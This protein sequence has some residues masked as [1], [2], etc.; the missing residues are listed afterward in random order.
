[1]ST[2]EA[3]ATNPPAGSLAAFLAQAGW[4]DASRTPI[5][6]DASGRRY[7]RLAGP[8]GSRILMVSPP[9]SGSVGS[10]AAIAGLLRTM[11]LSAPE[12]FSADAER[13]LALI[14]DFGD[15]SFAG[16][17]DRGA[18]PEPLLCLAVDA[19]A[20]L[21]RR[22]DARD[23]GRLALP[24]YDEDRLV[25][26]VML[27]ADVWLP[28]AFGRPAYPHERS[29]LE[30]AWRAVVRDAADL[31]WSFLH[32]DYFAG[33]LML[34]QGRDGIAACGLLDFQDA[35]FGPV[36]YDLV[37]LLEDARRDFPAPLA[38]RMVGRYLAAFPGLDPS[39]FRRGM[40]VLGAVRHTRIAAIFARLS[41]RDG[42]NGYLVHLPRVWRQLEEKLAQP[43]MTPV[44]T[45]FDAHLPP[46]L[47]AAPLAPKPI[48]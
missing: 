34:L 31:P 10:F 4:A 2:T 37:S 38:D 40:A 13:G 45:W 6:G 39:A 14:E 12:I 25:D 28:L 42:R 18:D 5:A 44:R 19:L 24:R 29:G 16:L 41:I 48:R 43:S 11:G 46:H 3:D 1:M 22:F 21:H 26:Q 33:N 23:A 8:K 32:R 20:A 17:L 35:G 15:S 7:E 47:R 27:F 30:A 36:C 9:G